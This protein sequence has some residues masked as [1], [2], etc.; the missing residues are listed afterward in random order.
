LAVSL[1]TRV[2]PR[3]RATQISEAEILS[4][5]A[6]AARQE[7][8]PMKKF[9]LVIAGGGLAAARA[10]K[11]YRESGGGQIAFLPKES[12]L[13]YHRPA[14]SKRYLRD[15]TADTPFAEDAPMDALE[16]ELVGGRSQ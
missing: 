6:C 14:L 10:I 5:P 8:D 16:R 11:S 13:P 12:D 4:P 7:E 1:R 9:E 3:P 15:E 2:R